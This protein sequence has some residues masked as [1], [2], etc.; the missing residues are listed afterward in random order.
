MCHDL[1]EYTIEKRGDA[2]FPLYTYLDQETYDICIKNL[3]DGKIPGP[4]KIPNF[5]LKNMPSKVHKLLLLLFTHCYKQKQIPESW[6][7]SLTIFLYKKGYPHHLTNHRPIAFVNTI[8]KLVTS[9]L[10]NTLSAYGE[11]IPNPT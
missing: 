7:T 11:K 9:T 3:A 2:L 1:N 10:T 8:Y 4:D 6:K 5:I